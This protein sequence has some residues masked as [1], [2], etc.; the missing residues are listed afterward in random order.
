MNVV[1]VH[2]S[3][4]VINWRLS[5]VSG[6]FLGQEEVDVVRCSAELDALLGGYSSIK[7]VFGRVTQ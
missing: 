7:V 5:S 2:A 3:W 1:L 4:R 6:S